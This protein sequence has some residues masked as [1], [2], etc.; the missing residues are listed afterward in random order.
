[1]TPRPLVLFVLGAPGIGKTQLVRHLLGF[2]CRKSGPPRYDVTPDGLQYK[3][4]WTTTAKGICAAGHYRGRTS[5]GRC[6]GEE[7]LDYWGYHLYLKVPVTLFDGSRWWN[8]PSQLTLSRYSC[9]LNPAHRPHFLGVHLGASPQALA[10]RRSRRGYG[11]VSLAYLKGQATRAR[12]V[13][14]SLPGCMYM[15]AEL[16]TEILG[17]MI[18]SR[19]PDYFPRSQS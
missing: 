4:P 15:N 12:N 18:G 1:M 5:D 11:A 16:S 17:L 9:A 3:G 19:F 10:A 7:P 14:K 13:A 2:T 6:G 8:E